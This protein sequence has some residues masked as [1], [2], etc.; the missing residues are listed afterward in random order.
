[1]T[2]YLVRTSEHNELPNNPNCEC[3]CRSEFRSIL[4][5]LANLSD[6]KPDIDKYNEYLYC[7]CCKRH[8]TNKFNYKNVFIM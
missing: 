4:R 3:I 7:H 1:M 2:K 5:F 6:Y 8:N